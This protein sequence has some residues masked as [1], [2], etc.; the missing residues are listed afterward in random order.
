MSRISSTSCKDSGITWHIT[1][2]I[3]AFGVDENDYITAVTIPKS[4]VL[5]NGKP[6]EHHAIYHIHVEGNNCFD[7]DKNISKWVVMKRFQ[8][9]NEFDNEIREFIKKKH[10]SN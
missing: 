10:P 3:E 5:R 2:D 1:N 8:D 9:F 6:K 7:D 4:Q